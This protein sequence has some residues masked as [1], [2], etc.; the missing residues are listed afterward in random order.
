MCGIQF[1][2][3]EGQGW[4][5]IACTPVLGQAP[6]HT[7]KLTRMQTV[8][9]SDQIRLEGAERRH[10][11]ILGIRESFPEEVMAEMAFKDE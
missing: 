3:R 7:V 6:G 2:P 1:W 10:L 4:E 5:L 11:P 8:A 9:M